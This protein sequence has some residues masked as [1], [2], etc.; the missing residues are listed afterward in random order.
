MT[1]TTLEKNFNR[2]LGNGANLGETF[3]ELIK[4]EG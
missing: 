2:A 3:N 4:G 1:Y